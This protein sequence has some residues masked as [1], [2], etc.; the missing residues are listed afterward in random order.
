MHLEM[1]NALKEMHTKVDDL[2]T[3]AKA[4]ESKK[5]TAAQLR[6]NI[7]AFDRDFLQFKTP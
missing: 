5:H 3:I 2:A 6:N 4:F 7:E 1:K